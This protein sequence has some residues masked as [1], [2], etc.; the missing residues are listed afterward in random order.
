M[1]A[2]IAT[3]QI[4][5]IILVGAGVIT[6][7]LVPVLTFGSRLSSRLTKTETIVNNMETKVRELDTDINHQ[8]DE[9]VNLKVDVELIKQDVKNIKTKIDSMDKKLDR[10]ID[11]K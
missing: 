2:A 9:G 1:I 3:I 6:G 4:W 11:R 10:L 7:I 5:H 8:R